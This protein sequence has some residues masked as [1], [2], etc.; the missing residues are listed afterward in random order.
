M[1]TEGCPR[2]TGS[3]AHRRLMSLRQTR[4]QTIGTVCRTSRRICVSFHRKD[5]ARLTTP[6]STSDVG[7][8]F[9]SHIAERLP[10]LPENH[11]KDYPRASTMRLPLVLLP[12][13]LCLFIPAQIPAGDG[14]GFRPMF[15]GKDLAGWVNVN[16]HPKTFFVKDNM[17]V[18]TG[19]PTGYLRTEKQ[20]ENFIAE[21]DWLHVNTKEVGNSGFFVWCDPIPAQGTG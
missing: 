16:C 17:I 2:L 14:D 19:F 11:T 7:H 20:Y 1:C 3:L 21:F 13:S 9:R 18:T 5:S 8:F 15:N 6:T 12:L 4:L 10:M